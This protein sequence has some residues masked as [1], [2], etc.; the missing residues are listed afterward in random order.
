SVRVWMGG[1]GNAEILAQ[2][3]V[4]CEREARFQVSAGLYAVVTGQIAYGNETNPIPSVSVQWLGTGRNGMTDSTGSYRINK[5]PY[6]QDVTLKPSKVRLSDVRQGTILSYDAALV[7]RSVVGLKKLNSSEAKA[8]D[9]DGDGSLTMNDAFRIARFAAGFDPADSDSIG[10][11]MFVPE[12]RTYR[13]IEQ[14]WADQNFSGV[15]VGDVHEGWGK[16]D[17]LAKSGSAD[18]GITVYPV[19]QTDSTLEIPFGFSGQGILSCDFACYFDP[20]SVERFD[21]STAVNAGLVVRHT[22]PG[23]RNVAWFRTDPSR[24]IGPILRF[25]V[26][27]KG[28]N[29]GFHIRLAKMYLNDVLIPDVHLDARG[30]GSTRHPDGLALH[31]NFP[32]PFN[33]STVLSYAIGE[34][35]HVRLTI[36]NVRGEEVVTMVDAPQAAGEHRVVW[37]GRDRDGRDAPSGC[38]F[39]SLSIGKRMI[40]GKMVKIP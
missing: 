4:I 31:P 25:I 20:T 6:R 18:P 10:K 12:F 34:A 37:N 11:W 16:S 24:S 39:Y 19:E 38:Y 3:D 21:V 5:L 9:A 40:S 15:L 29:D 14:D 1:I 36:W 17:P 13:A 2:A 22:E 27:M 23:K 8:A 35:S 32:N 30:V 28:I 33:A 26:K 7:A